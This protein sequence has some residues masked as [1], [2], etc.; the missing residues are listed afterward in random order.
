[1]GC[2]GSWETKPKEFRLKEVSLSEAT[3]KRTQRKHTAGF[4]TST[5]RT[6]CYISSLPTD[7]IQ[8]PKPED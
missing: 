8:K 5:Q 3:Q 7:L 1:M 2:R 4:L 6:Q